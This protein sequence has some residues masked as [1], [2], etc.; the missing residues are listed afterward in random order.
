MF[1]LLDAGSS[2]PHPRPTRLRAGHDRW[3]VQS[4]FPAASNTGRQNCVGSLV[5]R[6][7][8]FF[9]PWALGW[10]LLLSGPTV[11][12]WAD[13]SKPVPVRPHEAAIAAQSPDYA[14]ARPLPL[15]TTARPPAVT[16]AP[17]A[18]GPVG[19]RQDAAISPPP[20]ATAPTLAPFLNG[21]PLPTGSSHPGAT[22]AG[23]VTTR[24]PSPLVAAD[25]R[26]HSKPDPPKTQPPSL[27][28]LL[29]QFMAPPATATAGA[30][31]AAPPPAPAQ[32]PSGEPPAAAVPAAPAVAGDPE[33]GVIQ[34]AQVRQDDELGVIQLRNPLQDS[35]L[36]ILELRQISPPP[37]RNPWLFLSAYATASSSDNV[38][39]VE[40]PILGRFG[41]RSLRPGVSLTAFPTIGP[42]TNLLV[43]ARTSLL[44]YEEFGNSSYDELRLQAGVRHQFSR[45]VYGQ[46]S[47]SRQLLYE[48]G[49]GDQF[50]TN[51]GIEVTI[52]RRDSLTPQLTLD[53]YY[54]GQVFFSDPERFSNVLNSV[55]AYLS[56]RLTNQ[57]DTGVNYR[58]TISDFT[59]QSRNETY[60]RITGQLRYAVTPAMRL[61]VF[62]GVGYGRS[63]ESRITFDDTFFGIS[64][65][66][67]VSI[68]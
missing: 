28:P 55:G 9:K 10:L 38:F 39:L 40:D 59:Q 18:K 30:A 35:E 20:V 7:I 68:F 5:V 12:A 42:Q 19:E 52:G 58:L 64:F 41:D 6:Y 14:I 53:S 1:K 62:G 60:Q 37:R 44:R 36:G 48:E 13:A 51:T 11:P 47:L 46:F 34:V 17:L 26:P 45:R 3:G 56:Y 57:W 2:S 22:P 15:A 66:A 61:S 8:L 21:E 29:A 43:S 27:A 31:I 67:T 32:S 63:S 16:L 25:V 50:F 4:G 24:Y 23:L 33:L 65:N 54:Q 49:Y